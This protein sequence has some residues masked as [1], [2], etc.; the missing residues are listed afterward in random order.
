MS[1]GRV[2]FDIV[3][4]SKKAYQGIDQVTDA[5]KSA[6][7]KWEKS[8]KASTDNI[9]SSF[10]DLAKKIVAAFS[11]AKIGEFLKN[12]GME[13]LSLASDLQEVQNVVDTTFGAAGAAKIDAWAKSAITQ[14]GL[15]ETQ[16]KRFT[17]T[18]G[19]MMKS[20]G[21]SGDE[22]VS[23]STDLAGLAADMA[24]FYNLDF[25]TAFQKIRSGISGETEPLKQL[26]INM[27]VANLEAYALQKGLGKTFSEMSQ[28]EQTMLR[29]QYLMEATADAQGDFARTSD[30]Y[31]NGLR[32]LESNL[33]SLKTKLGGILMDVVNPLVAAI[34]SLFPKEKKKRHTVADDINEI[35]FDT[36]QK[37]EE[38]RLISAEATELVT[39]LDAI[40][41]FKGDE[42]L[43]NLATGANSLNASSARTWSSLV[44]SLTKINGLQNLFNGDTST[45]DSL[46]SA[47]AGDSVEMS[48]AEAWGVFLGA[49]GENADAVSK[50]TGKT[51]GETTEWLQGMAEAANS[52]NPEN[53]D[54]WNK[55]LTSF[56]SGISPDTKEG[57]QF[58]EGM[59]QAFLAMGSESNVAKAGLEGLGYN[60]TMIA[61]KQDA[62]LK[63][64]KELVK[65]IPGLS[66]IINTETGEIKGG[67][68]AVSEYVEE[69]R[70]GQEKILKW[71]SYFRKQ[72]ALNAAREE[73][74]SKALEMQARRRMLME[75]AKEDLRAW[76][77]AGGNGMIPVI[78][79]WDTIS[80]LE[81]MSDSAFYNAN[82]L[83]P[84]AGDAEIWQ[85]Y[86]DAAED[87]FENN[88][89][90][91][92]QTKVL[93]T[94]NE[95]LKEEY[96]ELTRE[97]VA[98]GMAASELTDGMTKLQRAASGDADAL[99]SVTTAVE[100]ADAA[101]KALADHA[102]N[103]HTRVASS[104]DGVVHGFEKLDFTQSSVRKKISQLTA[105][106]AQ[107][108][109]GSDEW[110]AVQKQI[111]EQ[112]ELL[113]SRDNMLAG[114]QSQADWMDSYLEDIEK[115]RE[116]GLSDSLLSYLADGS[117]DSY[118][119][120]HALVSEDPNQK[121]NAA[122]V[123]AKWEE[124]QAKKKALSDNLA[125]TQLSVDEVYQNLLD[126]AKRAVAELD[127]ASEAGENAGKTAEA[128]VKAVGD[129]V[130]PLRQNVDSILAQMARLANYNITFPRYSLGGMVSSAFINGFHAA[131]LNYV[132]FD[133]YLASLH[134]GEGI[135]T[136][137]ENR[138]WQQFKNNSRGVDYD[139]LGGVM[140]DNIHAGGNVY[141][142]GRV[143]G[144]VISDIQGKSYRQ[145]TRSGWQQ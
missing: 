125:D 119:A 113:T 74:D 11:A 4:D 42:A 131:G 45:I 139:Q 76:E 66:D 143:V 50:L 133:G 140:R 63:T 71:N 44:Q 9:G 109:I 17:S 8:A 92:D 98:A 31:A 123:N 115:A 87:Y 72:D 35:D 38:I 49:L 18:L 59:T 135:L 142:D 78:G 22:I 56:M 46:A 57:R 60:T 88:A 96:G 107:Y 58:I 145:L 7:N 94:Q 68:A 134:E 39:K 81:D 51:V 12:L 61:E 37:L 77:K 29:Y 10:A 95:M 30:G 47:L 27:S 105:D 64:C 132:P 112:N 127:L 43:K 110:K 41:G 99:A 104:I 28:A 21:M 144:N 126:E 122:Q 65:T 34:D 128:V 85:K 33:D 91:I 100:N 79:G 138:L 54:G 93:D 84:L 86:I 25:D 15:T 53:A 20:M 5:L 124:V 75:S 36:S 83:F 24:S 40:S 19:A 120:L 2:E 1:D 137:E 101:L 121:A 80:A 32:L 89:A 73:L 70:R 67:T 3:A 108:K 23:M 13:A 130:D 52:L 97:E 118:L 14:F 16:A 136:A 141:L 103:V 55:L 106:Q 62:W 114:L 48:K 90:I 117:M 129:E 69:W 26:G 82:M 6:G 111:D 102:E 116:L